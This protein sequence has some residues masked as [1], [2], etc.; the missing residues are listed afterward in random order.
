M[1]DTHTNIRYT[2]LRL[3]AMGAAIPQALLLLHALL[4]ILPYPKGEKGMWYEIHTGS[5][6]CIDEVSRP[7]TVNVHGPQGSEEAISLDD[8]GRIEEDIGGM[9]EDETERKS[10]VKVSS[11]F[12]FAVQSEA[13]LG[14]VFHPDRSA[15][16]GSSPSERTGS[17]NTDRIRWE[18]A[19]SAQQKGTRN[20]CE[21][22]PWRAL[23]GRRG[24][25]DKCSGGN[26]GS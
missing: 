16:I 21:T 7:E 23:G 8:L 18:T 14:I 12:Y 26:R 20:T 4:D 2:M 13:F 11:I 9:E 19:E 17:S 1:I 15:H 10:R 5:V 3:H 6:E 22:E 25:D 24:G